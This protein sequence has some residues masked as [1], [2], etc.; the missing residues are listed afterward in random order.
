MSNVVDSEP[1]SLGTPLLPTINNV[2]ISYRQPG[3]PSSRAHHCPPSSDAATRSR[4]ATTTTMAER[5]LSGPQG[6]E[7]VLFYGVDIQVAHFQYRPACS[8]STNSISIS[9][10]EAP[11]PT[12]ATPRASLF[13]GRPA[14]PS[15]PP[16]E[17]SG[18]GKKPQTGWPCSVGRAFFGYFLSAMEPARIACLLDLV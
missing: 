4:A 8:L 11:P 2:L 17:P 5:P 10:T 13:N 14:A 1:P 16:S 3:R 9:F 7:Q 12:H 6:P 18:S 15:P